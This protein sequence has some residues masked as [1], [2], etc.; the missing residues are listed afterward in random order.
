MTSQTGRLLVRAMLAE[1]EVARLMTSSIRVGSQLG[2]AVRVSETGSSATDDV[3]NR[4]WPDNRYN[5]LL[6]TL[7]PTL[8][9]VDALALL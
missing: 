7:S 5:F 1:P 8:I 2:L 3:T 6:T 9:S 4:K